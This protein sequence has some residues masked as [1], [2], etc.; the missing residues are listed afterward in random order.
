MNSWIGF[1]LYV[2]A[3]V[4]LADERKDRASPNSRS[5]LEFILTAMRAIGKTHTVTQHFIAQIELDLDASGVGEGWLC[6]KFHAVNKPQTASLKDESYKIGANDLCMAGKMFRNTQE[7][8]IG[9]PR[10]MSREVRE[11]HPLPNGGRPYP[12]VLAGDESSGSDF[13]AFGTTEAHDA[14]NDLGNT[15]SDFALPSGRTPSSE[16][17]ST[18]MQ[19]PL[20]PPHNSNDGGTYQTRA[21]PQDMSNWGFDPNDI[22]PFE[23]SFGISQ[24]EDELNALLDGVN[25]ES[26]Q[27]Q[28]AVSQ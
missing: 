18:N 20:Q 8:A 12:G 11:S 13:L 19:Y 1:C 23:Q 14:S 26:L 22:V 24:G 21:S 9:R 6:R 16:S 10:Q 5:N 17:S 7:L 28:P 2:A 4:F 25:W 15:D 27:G 3:G